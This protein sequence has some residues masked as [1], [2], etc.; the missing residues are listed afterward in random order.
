MSTYLPNYLTGPSQIWQSAVSLHKFIFHDFF[1]QK[2]ISY[3]A[4]LRMYVVLWCELIVL[5]MQ[6][7]LSYQIVQLQSDPKRRFDD[8]LQSLKRQQSKGWIFSDRVHLASWHC[9]IFLRLSDFTTSWSP[10]K[11][12][13]E[14]SQ[15]AD[16]WH[17]PAEKI[18]IWKK[19]MKIPW[20][21]RTAAGGVLF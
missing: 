1:A 15:A 7:H 8:D 17:N 13:W 4:Y 11:K 2:K 20:K 9:G 6:K 18:N 21:R 12:S 10:L 3:R 16:V 5:N 14:W 19:V